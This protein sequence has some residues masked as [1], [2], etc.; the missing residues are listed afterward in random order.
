MI[1][2]TGNAN[3]LNMGRKNSATITQRKKRSKAHL[4]QKRREQEF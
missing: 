4:F 3:A 1:A 2:I